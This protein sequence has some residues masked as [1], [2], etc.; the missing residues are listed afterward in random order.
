MRAVTVLK[1][2]WTLA[3]DF[4]QS[5]PGNFSWQE[6][7]FLQTNVKKVVLAHVAACNALKCFQ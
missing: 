5:F 7:K 1:L 3:L 6:E 4:L 2:L